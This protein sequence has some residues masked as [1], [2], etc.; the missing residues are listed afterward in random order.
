MNKTAAMM[1]MLA[2]FATPCFIS[3]AIAADKGTKKKSEGGPV[4]VTGKISTTKKDA[5]DFTSIKLTTPDGKVYNITLDEKGKDLAKKYEG[6]SAVVNG[7]STTKDKDLWLTVESI[8]EKK[9]K[10]K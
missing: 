5:D 3:S 7:T 6:I 2:F 8:G 9:K 1:L 10:K 4:S